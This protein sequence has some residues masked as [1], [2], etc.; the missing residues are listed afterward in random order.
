MLVQ[1]TCDT[2]CRDLILIRDGGIAPSYFC[3]PQFQLKKTGHALRCRVSSPAKIWPVLRATIVV[4]RLLRVVM[5]A[6]EFGPR[7]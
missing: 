4:H 5:A 1:K 2:L 6:C 7:M 3:R